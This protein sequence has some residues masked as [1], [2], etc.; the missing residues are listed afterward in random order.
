MK[1]KYERFE[2]LGCLY[3]RGPVNEKF[4][5][6]LQVGIETISKDLEETLVINLMCAQIQVP[7]AAVLI[8]FKTK[9][10]ETT[11]Q[12]LYWVSKDRTIG[13]FQ[14]IDM[15]IS[16]LPGAKSRQ[17]GERIKADDDVYILTEQ[18]AALQAKITQLGGNE[19]QVIKMINDNT[20]YKEQ[21][22]I[23]QGC[24]QFQTAR[25]KFQTPQPPADKEVGQKTEEAYALLRQYL[26]NKDVDL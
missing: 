9:I 3:V 15:F 5:K 2:G 16:R 8:E 17:V 10:A 21:R 19:D 6:L 26:G 23:L 7:Q 14:S 25:V 4:G 18:I 22:R 1:L 13:D 11:K 20:S 24:I 12:K